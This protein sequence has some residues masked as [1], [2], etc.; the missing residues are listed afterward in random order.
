M[1]VNSAHHQAVAAVSGSVTVNAKA[2]DGVIEGIES[3]RQ[4]FCLGVQWHPEFE[5]DPND[6]RIFSAFIN[7]A[8][9]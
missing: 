5:V 8:R 7:A 1:R 3:S 4:R 6:M 9:N 2:P